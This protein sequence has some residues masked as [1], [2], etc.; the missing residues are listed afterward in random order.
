ME[1][2]FSARIWRNIHTLV[3]DHDLIDRLD[4]IIDKHLLTAHDRVLPYFD[5]VQP[6][7]ANI[8]KYVIREIETY[9]G[10]IVDT[11]LGLDVYPSV[12]TYRN[13]LHIQNIGENG[14]IVRCEVPDHINI[15][16]E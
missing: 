15:W 3:V 13:R 6:A 16:L 14:Q 1:F 12:C 10:Y 5:G 7:H 11:F 9:V 4:I 8:G 2:L